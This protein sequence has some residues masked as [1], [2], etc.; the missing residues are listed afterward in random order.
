MVRRVLYADMR[1]S[2]E[3]LEFAIGANGFL[4]RMVRT[5]VGTL[6][7]RERRRLRGIAVE[8]TIATLLERGDRSLAGSTAPPWG[9]FLQG[10]RYDA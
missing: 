8:E 10:V 6:I 7:E 3:R 4:R 2:G 1:R 5:I 9:L